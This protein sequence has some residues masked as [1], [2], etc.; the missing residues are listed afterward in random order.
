MCGAYGGAGCAVGCGAVG[1]G[2]GPIRARRSG[3]DAAR[4]VSGGGRG[5]SGRRVR[6][7]AASAAAGATEELGGRDADRRAH[8]APE[9]NARQ[10]RLPQTRLLRGRQQRRLARRLRGMTVSLSEL[11]ATTLCSQ[12]FSAAQHST[13]ATSARAQANEQ[14]I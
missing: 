14:R 11:L 7:S 10:R 3:P 4:P 9:A 1:G 6:R 2:C 5:R 8:I 12:H 13:T